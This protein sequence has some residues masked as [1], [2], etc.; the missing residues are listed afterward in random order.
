MYRQ[1]AAI[2]VAISTTHPPTQLN[3]YSEKQKTVTKFTRGDHSTVPLLTISLASGAGSQNL[4]KS[5]HPPQ[6]P[7]QKKE[8]LKW[9]MTTPAD[10]SKGKPGTTLSAHHIASDIYLQYLGLTE[11]QREALSR[12]YEVEGFEDHVFDTSEGSQTQHHW[13]FTQKGPK[14]KAV[15]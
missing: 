11:D 1:L 9:I 15:L 2:S 5:Q 7:K 4:K 12:L 3:P 13:C 8:A 6:K 14:M 10:M